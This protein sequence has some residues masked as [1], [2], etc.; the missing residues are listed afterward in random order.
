MNGSVESIGFFQA[1]ELNV[2]ISGG[3]RVGEKKKPDLGASQC[4]GRRNKP[5]RG[6]WF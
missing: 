6:V 5:P 4:V 1:L 2:S 3:L